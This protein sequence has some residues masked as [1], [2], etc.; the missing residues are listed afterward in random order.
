[1]THATQAQDA[2]SQKRDGGERSSVTDRVGGR[3]EDGKVDVQGVKRVLSDITGDVKT[4]V[5]QEVALAKA[6]ITGEVSKVGKAAGMLVG[7]AFAALMIIIFL[8]T[9]L[10][11]ALANIMDQS[12]AALIVAG[13]WTLI[14]AVLA[15]VGRGLL[16][17]ISLTPTRTINSLKQLPGAVKAQQGELR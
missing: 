17:S 6:E 2:R 5:Q 7:A 12:W 13:V 1:M 10:W 8:S 4:L 15:V 3:P 9:A 14:A 16:K 11:W